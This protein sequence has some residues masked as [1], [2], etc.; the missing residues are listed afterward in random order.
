MFC[1]VDRVHCHKLMLTKTKTALIF[2]S[3]GGVK[4]GTLLITRDDRNNYSTQW[5]AV[6]CSLL[7]T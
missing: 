6:I 2:V 4:M 1:K 3:P 7:I 5:K